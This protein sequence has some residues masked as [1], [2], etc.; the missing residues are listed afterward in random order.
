MTNSC[1]TLDDSSIM[2]LCRA[3]CCQ[4]CESGES[5]WLPVRCERAP[6][7]RSTCT[8]SERGRNGIRTLLR[9]VEWRRRVAASTLHVFR[10]MNVLVVLQSVMGMCC[11]G[12]V[13]GFLATRCASLLVCR[14]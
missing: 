2:Q 13:R 9:S 4:S 7:R 10:C 12:Q 14:T 6:L 11:A 5:K 3:V 1:L 8:A